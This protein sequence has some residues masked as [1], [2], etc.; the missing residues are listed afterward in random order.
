[1]TEPYALSWYWS[2]QQWGNEID[3]CLLPVVD[4]IPSLVWLVM[5]DIGCGAFQS[6]E[7]LIQQL[8]LWRLGSHNRDNQR[9][10]STSLSSVQSVRL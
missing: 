5:N 9:Q 1:M 6:L 8:A 10:A 3:A 2:R 7:E 4:N